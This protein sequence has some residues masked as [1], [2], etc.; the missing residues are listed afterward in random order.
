MLRA[1]SPKQ[2]WDYCGEW[3][4]AI[5]RLTAHDIPSLHDWVPCKVVE[6][7]TPDISKY[8]QFDWYQ[9]IWNH[10]P[11]VQFP[12]DA[13]KLGRWIGVAQDV[14]SPMT[15][16]VSPASCRVSARSTVS[17]IGG[18]ARGPS[19]QEQDGRTRLGDCRED[20]K[21]DC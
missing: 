7:N 17:V 1:R 2:L 6:G 4:S 20:W 16:W 14:G 21:R 3:V 8:A 11:A 9:Y 19:C 10:D 18:R 15:F 13:R 5:K 12:E